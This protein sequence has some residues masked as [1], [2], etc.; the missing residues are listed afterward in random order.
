[1]KPFSV[2]V[3]V[4][5][6]ALVIVAGCQSSSQGPPPKTYGIKGIVVAVDAKKQSIK[7][8]HQDIPG[9]MKAMVMDFDVATPKVVEGLKPGDKVEG[10][11]KVEAGNA[12]VTAL[13]KLP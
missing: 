11:L 7:L 9:F 1:V 6:V 10:K 5:S 4:L 12:T 3:V 8:D 13:D 2:A